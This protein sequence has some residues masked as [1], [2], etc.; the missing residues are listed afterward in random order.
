LPPSGTAVA[1][2]RAMRDRRRDK[3]LKLTEPSEGTVKCFLDVIVQPS[4]KDEWI[5]IS[6]EPAH[7]GETLMLDVVVDEPG[8]GELREPAPVCV[9]ESR[10]IILDGDMRH[11]IR[12]HGGDLTPVLFEQIRLG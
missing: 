6:R 12:L 3:R 8:D 9:I 4:G 11:R 5:A 10:P 1:T 7:I 2:R